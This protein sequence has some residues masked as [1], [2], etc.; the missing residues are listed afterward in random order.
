MAKNIKCYA[1]GTIFP[2]QDSEIQVCPVCRRR[3]KINRPQSNVPALKPSSEQPRDEYESIREEYLN[4]M[5][6]AIADKN[7]D[8]DDVVVISK[9]DYDALVGGRLAGGALSQPGDTMQL[10]DE[11]PP[12]Y[13]EDNHPRD[14]YRDDRREVYK[15]GRGDYRDDYRDD[16]RDDYRDGYREDRRDYGDDYLDEPSGSSGQYY[17]E[18]SGKDKIGK[19]NAKKSSGGLF[20]LFLLIVAGLSVLPAFF[21]PSEV[22][23]SILNV[24]LG[25]PSR[26]EIAVYIAVT[27]F[28]AVLSVILIPLRKK[29]APKIIFGLLYV[30]AGAAFVFGS[31]L[32]EMVK[33]F[34]SFD[35]AS[36]FVFWEYAPLIVII[37][38]GACAL[39]GILLFFIGIFQKSVRKDSS[40]EREERPEERRRGKR[41][42]DDEYGYSRRRRE[43]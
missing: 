42:D 10:L 22:S 3:M 26:R 13:R 1:C 39:A 23:D 32:V 11:Y 35:F 18:D 15:G 36:T 25:S 17:S 28:P 19:K 31:K 21:F 27:V 2:I 38:G 41:Y 14:D 6:D 7:A 43:R 8:P 34:A 5:K 29:K 30:L 16:R 37:C 9:S 33:D 20:P 24:I 4:M 12:R 40:G